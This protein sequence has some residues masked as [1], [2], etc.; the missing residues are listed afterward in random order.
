MIM[1]IQGENKDLR[2]RT[3][4]PSV[5]EVVDA[6]TKTNG[7]LS[8]AAKMLGVTRQTVW[9]W[10]KNEPLIAEAIKESRKKLFDNCLS[11]AQIVAL[12]V[13]IKDENG[14][15]VGWQERPDSQM[16]RYLMGII[17]RDEGFGEVLDVTSGGEKIS[18][19]LQIEI[20]D[21]RDKV[22]KKDEETNE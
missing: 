16:L 6:L 21:S 8:N 1:N 4:R 9:L 2:P 18:S 20:I 5:E 7:H 22:E 15:F 10:A 13:P 3:S 19:G 12:G 14:K 11:T 17:G